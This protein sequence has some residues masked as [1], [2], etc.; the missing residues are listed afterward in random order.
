MPLVN[1]NTLFKITQIPSRIGR[2]MSLLKGRAL[3]DAAAG[4]LEP[5]LR[6][7]WGSCDRQQARHASFAMPSDRTPELV[8]T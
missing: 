7:R 3:N 2:R 1:T 6:L 5:A 8:S 4:L